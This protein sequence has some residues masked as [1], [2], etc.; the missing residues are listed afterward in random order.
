MINRSD[1]IF[2]VSLCLLVAAL[3]VGYFQPPPPPNDSVWSHGPSPEWTAWEFAVIALFIFS[4]ILFM[5][6]V[7][8]RD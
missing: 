4:G 7:R 5:I 1:T 2:G 8:L 3:L 6:A